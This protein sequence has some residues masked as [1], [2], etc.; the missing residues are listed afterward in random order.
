MLVMSAAILGRH[1]EGNITVWFETKRSTKTVLTS[2]NQH[3]I[4]TVPRFH[5]C[6]YRAFGFSI[7]S[8][9]WWEKKSD[10]C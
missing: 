7:R 1:K 8:P 6:L 2:E 10:P 5:L 3:E 9:W 4:L